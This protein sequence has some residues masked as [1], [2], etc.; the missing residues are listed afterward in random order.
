MNKAVL[1]YMLFSST[2]LIWFV[3]NINGFKETLKGVVFSSKT[4][5]SSTTTGQKFYRSRDF[6]FYNCTRKKRI[7]GLPNH[8]AGTKDE[9]F[10]IDG[11]FYSRNF[12]FRSV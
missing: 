10:R 12:F 5:C 9:L 1:I 8:V 7:G 6:Q 3:F 2:I 4:V 11:Y